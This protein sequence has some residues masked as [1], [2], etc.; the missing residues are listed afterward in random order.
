[1]LATAKNSAPV[2]ATERLASLDVLRAL[3]LFGVLIVN[4]LTEFRVSI[5][6]QFLGPAAGSPWDRRI[7]RAV[8]VAVESKAFVLFSFLF[9]VGLAIQVDRARRAGRAFGPQIAR[10]LG[11][12]LALGLVH[13]VVIWNGDI[14]T[15]YAVAGAFVAL[16]VGLPRPWLLAVAAILLVVY[17]SPLPFP[18]PFPTPDALALHVA[19]ANRAYGGGGFATVLSFRIHELPPILALDLAVLPRTLAL[20]ALGGWAWRIGIFERPA[21]YRRLLGTTAG[22]GLL[23]GGLASAWIGGLLGDTQPGLEAWRSLIDRL[24]P[25]A[26]ALGYGAGLLLLFELPIARRALAPFAPLGQMALTNYLSQSVIFGFVFYGY[27]LGQFGKM[28]MPR[29]ALLG[30]LVYATQIAA[31]AWWLRRFR[32][33]PVEWVWRCATYKSWQPMRR[34]SR[35]QA[36]RMTERAGR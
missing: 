6:E 8:A 7:D 36:S 31:S 25:M 26:L 4:L 30:L 27:G 32:F 22:L 19:E 3:A 17:V 11:T 24:G 33:G 14:L 12:L 9:G 1:V 29:A 13:L 16:L 10:R 21:E 34:G 28:S 5:F 20:F 15:E 35:D 2:A 18:D 23:L